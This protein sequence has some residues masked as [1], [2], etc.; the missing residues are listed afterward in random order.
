F[1]TYAAATAGTVG[2]YLGTEAR[3]AFSWNRRVMVARG[4]RRGH[5]GL[6]RVWPRLG[7]VGSYVDDTQYVAYARCLGHIEQ[8]LLPGGFQTVG[9]TS[10]GGAGAQLYC[11]GNGAGE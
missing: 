5:R 7:C 2:L 1:Q 6:T 4:S 11:D 9:E 3:L 10:D 8:L